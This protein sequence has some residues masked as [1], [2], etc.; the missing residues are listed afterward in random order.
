MQRIAMEDLEA[1][2]DLVRLKSI[3]TFKMEQ[4]KLSY[5]PSQPPHKAQMPAKKTLSRLIT[6]LALATIWT[7][8]VT[9]R[10]EAIS[11]D[12]P[13]R[14]YCD[15]KG[16]IG[17]SRGRSS[18]FDQPRELQPGEMVSIPTICPAERY[19][20]T[21]VTVTP[22]ATYQ[23]DATGL[24]KDGW[25]TVGPEGW[26]GLLL[27]AW[28]R[29]RWQKFFLLS[30]SIGRSDAETFPIGRGKTWTAPPRIADT[31]ST[32]LFLFPNDWPSKIDNNRTVPGSK[33]GP[34]RVSIRRLR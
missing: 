27:Q 2:L 26:P 25:I 6:L 5:L 11:P 15:D 31:E 22:N 23:I 30:G 10:A 18:K 17:N 16:L 28:N 20:P 9:A 33:G 34:L 24:W 19:F 3:N 12:I 29:V 14:V 4:P 7:A 13:N 1:A 32:E 21:G 8:P